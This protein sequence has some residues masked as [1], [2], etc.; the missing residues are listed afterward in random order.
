MDKTFF[1]EYGGR[2]TDIPL[3]TKGTAQRTE[4]LYS[5][6]LRPFQKHEH[7]FP[8]KTAPNE[9]SFCV[10]C[11]VQT[12]RGNKENAQTEWAKQ[13]VGLHNPERNNNVI[14]ISRITNKAQ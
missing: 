11:V 3:R 10:L 14:A 12:H 13:F 7:L 8:V 1:T 2:Q 5:L 9:T 6:T 4:Q